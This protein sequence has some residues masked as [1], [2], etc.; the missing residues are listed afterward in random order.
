MAISQT[1]T[2]AFA[3]AIGE[4]EAAD[5]AATEGKADNE[6][7]DDDARAQTQ[8][9]EVDAE[10]TETEESVLT[11]KVDVAQKK[12]EI[13]KFQEKTQNLIAA[14][15]RKKRQA[16][17]KI[18]RLENERMA[19]LTREEEATVDIEDGEEGEKAGVASKITARA[20]ATIT[21]STTRVASYKE[22]IVYL[23]GKISTST[24][25]VVTL[26]EKVTKLRTLLD[27]K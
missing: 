4:E 9:Q 26:R 2:D 13:L 17:L 8:K 16:L 5:Q 6:T 24:T 10:S 14:A 27:T 1:Q 3:S 22:K 15:L 18:I 19:T 23:V 7:A 25:K 12:L 21:L 20:E 11:D